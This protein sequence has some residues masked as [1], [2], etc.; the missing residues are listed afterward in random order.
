VPTRRDAPPSQTF[1]A[2]ALELLQTRLDELADHLVE[3]IRSTV[4]EYRDVPDL[5]DSELRASCRDNLRQ[6]L[7]E[8]A[9]EWK[10]DG[11]SIMPQQLTGERRAQQELSLEGL[12]HAY[13]LGG[14]VLWEGLVEVARSRPSADYDLLLNEATSVWD[15]IDR[16]SAIVASAYRRERNRLDRHRQR[17]R[18][19]LLAALVEGAGT[20]SEVARGAAAALGMPAEGPKLLVVGAYEP[21]GAEPLR[22]PEEALAVH[23]LASA[24]HVRSGR[25]IGLVATPD[26]SEVLALAVLAGCAS[27]PVAVAPVVS[28]LDEMPTA[29]ELADLTLRT[30]PNGY[31]GLVQ[32]SERLPETLLAVSPDL[33][34]ILVRATFGDLLSTPAAERS[35]LLDTLRVLL[36]CDGSPLH[37][38][39]QL[40]CHRNTVIKRQQRIERLTARRLSNP[41]DRLHLQL[42][43]LALCGHG[44]ESVS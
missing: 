43:V 20:D 29:Y 5:D 38:A 23:G 10:P 14:R 27:G 15:V 37:A 19:A 9:G 1:H 3:L 39:E 21:P 24:W 28:S 34:R 18:Q 31:S 30:L 13:R 44:P 8:L 2:Y 42:A 41:S 36:D 7:Q 32:V 11:A 33:T 6:A 17:R 22:S 25:E 16:H 26:G 35:V 12:L 40:H 4:E